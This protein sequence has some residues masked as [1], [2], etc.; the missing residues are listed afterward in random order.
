MGAVIATYGW[1]GRYSYRIPNDIAGKVI[2][3]MIHLWAWKEIIDLIFWY[4]ENAMLLWEVAIYSLIL[5]LLVPYRA[6]RWMLKGIKSDT[7]NLEK[8][9]VYKLYLFP[10]D[11]LFF[12]TS[13]P[14]LG[15]SGFK[16]LIVYNNQ[17]FL[18]GY[19]RNEYKI[20]RPKKKALM[21]L[22][23]FCIV[24]YEKRIEDVEQFTQEQM[25]IRSAWNPLNNTC[26]QVQSGPYKKRGVTFHSILPS[27]DLLISEKNK[28]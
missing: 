6:N 8:D 25:E 10:T 4:N 13:L 19:Q 11:F 16:T 3:Y 14:G 2:V 26:M 1:L 23:S 9:G 20:V 24:R 22:L 17:F 28:K 12:I 18:C 15:V 27:I 21:K 5:F 7:V